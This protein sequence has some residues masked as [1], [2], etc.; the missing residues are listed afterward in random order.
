[1]TLMTELISLQ[2]L[3]TIQLCQVTS[4]SSERS[5]S[6]LTRNLKDEAIRET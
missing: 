1:V 4:K 6:G 2:P 3:R 5:V